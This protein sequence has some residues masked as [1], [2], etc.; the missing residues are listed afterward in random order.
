MGRGEEELGGG[1]EKKEIKHYLLKERNTG[2][3]VG[4]IDF[5]TQLLY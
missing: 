3:E 4:K 1:V 5:E 2:R